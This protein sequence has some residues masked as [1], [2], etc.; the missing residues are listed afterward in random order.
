MTEKILVAWSKD[1]LQFVKDVLSYY[2]EGFIQK[3]VAKK[4]GYSKHGLILKLL[5]LGLKFGRA[6]RLKWSATEEV[7]DIRDIEISHLERDAV[8][9]S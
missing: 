1:D 6:G 3:V 2:R 4:M 7:F 5:G 8:A 9:T